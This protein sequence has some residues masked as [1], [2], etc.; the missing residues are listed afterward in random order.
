[1]FTQLVVAKSELA[2]MQFGLRI[3]LSLMCY[4][5]D[6]WSDLENWWCYLYNI[7]FP[8]KILIEYLL[9]LKYFPRHL[10]NSQFSKWMAMQSK[11]YN[12]TMKRY[13]YINGSWRK[14][15]LSLPVRV[16]T[17]LKVALTFVNKLKMVVV[18][19]LS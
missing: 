3:Q 15:Q 17:F 5:I 2:H 6:S 14:D 8:F 10:W 9:C 4:Y 12:I 19:G 13:I 16:K 1:M 18:M 7:F 11:S